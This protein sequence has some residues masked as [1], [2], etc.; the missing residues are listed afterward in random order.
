MAI[1]EDS[2]APVLPKTPS[3]ATN[4]RNYFLALEKKPVPENKKTS[5][6]VLPLECVAVLFAGVFVILSV[7]GSVGRGGVGAKSVSARGNK[8][9]TQ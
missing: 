5:V 4:R 2:A 6:F 8:V 7:V 1:W 3:P 9:P